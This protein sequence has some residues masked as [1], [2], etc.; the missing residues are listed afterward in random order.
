MTRRAK[1]I[2]GIDAGGT[3]TQAILTN[4]QEDILVCGYGGRPA[5]PTRIPLAQACASLTEAADEVMRD[6][7]LRAADI[8]AICLGVAGGGKKEYQ[9]EITAAIAKLGITG[10]ILVVS[11][12]VTAFWS[13]I[14]EGCGVIAIAGTGSSAYG[15]NRQG[16]AVT[17]GGWGYLVG[18][19]GSAFDIGRSGINAALKACE[20]R[21]PATLLQDKLLPYLQLNTFEEVRYAIYNP[22]D[23][24]RKLVISQFAPL[25]TQTAATG[26]RVAQ[27]I[28]G[29]AG[30]ELG[31]N[32]ISVAQRLG[33]CHQAFKVGLVGGVFKA[34]VLVISAL[35]DTV[36]QS[37]PQADIFISH[38]SPSLGA[39]RLAIQAIKR[40][41]SI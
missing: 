27:N 29:R 6:G 40:D 28:L 13:A 21:G 14:P 35:R 22:L 4:L 1:H 8:A 7:G 30:N 5:N 36:L 34:G 19:E 9:A 10:P 23:A 11:D 2:I 38:T 33:L 18:D 20:G 32:I 41:D 12:V 26:D 39:A 31:L 24:G 37:A 3:K 16:R 15:I 17:A 25:V